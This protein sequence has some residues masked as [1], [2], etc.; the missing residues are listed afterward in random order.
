MPELSDEEAE[1]TGVLG[2]GNESGVGEWGCVI[3]EA[4]GPKA[5]EE[6]KDEV[7]AADEES[8]GETHEAGGDAK[9]GDEPEGVGG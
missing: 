4:V 2:D 1:E 7:E 8:C 9:V 3:G 6:A 5:S